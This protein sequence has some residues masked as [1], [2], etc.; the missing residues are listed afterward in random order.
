MNPTPGA[1]SLGDVMFP[2]VGNGGYDATR[3]EINLRYAPASNSFLA[4]TATTMTARAKKDLS[5]FSLDFEGLAVAGVSVGG[6]PAAFKR[7][8]PRACSESPPEVPPCAKTKLVIT[9]K[10]PIRE[11]ALFTA[12]ISY[13]GVPVEHTDP[14]GSIEG[15][16]R[17]CATAGDPATCDGAFVVNEPIG[18]MTWFPSN[19]H[20]IDKARIETSVTVPSTHKAIGVGELEPTVDN[21][22]GTTT[23]TWVEDDP[24][25]TYLTTATVG[26][27]DLT[28]GSFEEDVNAQS[29]PLYTAIDSG[30]SPAEKLTASAA[31][32]ET[33]QII[34]FFNDLY[35]AYP[36]DSSGAVVDQAADVGYALEVQ[37]KPHYPS[38]LSPVRPTVVHELAHQWFGNAVTLATWSDIWFNE[39]WAQ[40]SDWYHSAPLTATPGVAEAEWQTE[41]NDGDTEKWKLAPAVLDGDPA[42]LFAE[43]PTYIRGAMTLEGY[44]QIVG[45]ARFFEFAR[46]L[47]ARFRY[48]NVSTQQVIGLALE[49]SDL[50]GA[51]ATLL[52]DY[53]DQWLYGTSRPTITPASF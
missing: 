15:W 52:D 35:G 5:Q 8:A 16:I 50:T 41:Y 3:Y 47:T 32:E 13:R 14:D 11:D 43:F 36:F 45:D 12:R 28:T 24:T 53:F 44:R 42:N 48:G 46:E 49:I 25:A 34:N 18:A 19:N 26:L 2:E 31:I 7:V 30:C 20:P 40:W 9:P 29:L 17:A 23:W 27:F 37:T 51:Q 10:K 4:G 33:P 38:C 6:A 21:G 22:N 1:R 39:G